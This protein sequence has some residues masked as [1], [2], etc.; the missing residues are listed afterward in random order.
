MKTENKSIYI[1]SIQG[2]YIW[3]HMERGESLS[4]NYVGAV[5]YSLEQI[6]LLETG[7]KTKKQGKK[8]ISNDIINLKFDSGVKS[9]KDVIKMKKKKI[10]EVEEEIVKLKEQDTSGMKKDEKEKIAKKIE[11]KEKYLNDL[12]VYVEMV[13]VENKDEDKKEKWKSIKNTELRE[14]LYEK[15]FTIKFVNEK[16]KKVKEVQYLV[17]KRSSSKS[18][19]GEV[20]F[21]RKGL[22]KS[23]RDWS[24]MHLD[25]K[26]NTLCDMPSLLAYESLVSSTIQSLL[27]IKTENMLLI[28]DIEHTFPYEANVVK[29]N[30]ETGHLDSF[31]EKEAQITNNLFDGQSLLEDSEEYFSDEKSMVLLRQHMFKSCAFRCSIQQW[32]KDKCPESTPYEEFKVYDAFGTPMLAKNVKFVF[33]KTSLKCLK[34]S[35][36]MPSGTEKEMYEY[37]K[38]LISQKESSIFGVVKQ[39]KKSTKGFDNGK[40][41][42][43]TSY[44][45]LN[46]MPLLEEDILKLSSFEM[47]Y[48]DA[49]RNNDEV[50]IKHATDK[51]NSVNSNEM[52]VDLYHINKE[53][54]NIQPFKD[55]RSRV[56]NDH[57]E[58]IKKGKLRLPSDY[59][60]IIAEPIAMLQ[61]ITKEFDIKKS[62]LTLQPNEVYTKLHDFDKEL[63]LCRNP[64][65]SA[66]NVVVSFNRHNAEI[67]KYFGNLSENI[68]VIPLRNVPLQDRFSGSDQ[69]SDT[70]L[71]MDSPEMLPAA[72]TCYENYKVCVNG[73]KTQSK[74][75]NLSDASMS[76]IDNDLMASKFNIG[77]TVN[78]SQLCVSVYNDA[79][80]RGK[81]EPKNVL[82]KIDSLSILAGLAIDMCKKKVDIDIED[83]LEYI[84]SDLKLKYRIDTVQ[85]K[86][87]KEIVEEQVK[88][89]LK[90]LFWVNVSDN[91]NAGKKLT[92]YKTSMDYLQ[93]IMKNTPNSIRRDAVPL[94]NFIKDYNKKL[95]DRKQRDKIFALGEDLQ[96]GVSSVFLKYIGED[97]DT[98]E[99]R[100]IAQDDTYEFYISK[101]GK[102]NVKYHTMCDIIAKLDNDSNSNFRVRLMNALYKAN[103]DLFLSVF[104]KA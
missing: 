42:N 65:T 13:E 22:R 54:V 21:I 67:E 89:E 47:S 99:E 33:T 45:I 17:Y 55:F 73:I 48:I 30:E 53:I 1:G 70:L 102:L 74:P 20:L 71:V 61:S 14:L 16:T 80:N 78:L 4:L 90:P 46:S 100:Y 84:K 8:T 68:I 59:C 23:M 63:I 32:L 26:E 75:Y 58:H 57:I 83:E 24:R 93:I 60:V 92:H 104:K 15:G 44:Q 10:K 76:A 35:N 69:D 72:R 66:S 41:L 81:K 11:G 77:N 19:K 28:D 88:V 43:Q 31:Y 34:F 2:A 37:W 62:K 18:R 7:L 96:K 40:I 29:K 64:H 51:K 5:P 9:A 27:T 103:K 79:V 38:K 39:E 87:K 97:D 3:E 49:L 56:V 52:F 36:I 94:S 12:N 98:K 86:V 50:F 91:E 25:F 95:S 6:K 85:K 82:K 101:L